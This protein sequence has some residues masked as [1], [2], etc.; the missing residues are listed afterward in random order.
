MSNDH[1]IACRC[2]QSGAMDSPRAIDRR[3]VMGNRWNRFADIR[4]GLLIFIL[5]LIAGLVPSSD[6]C[7]PGGRLIRR[8]PKS[9]PPLV[10]K[11]HIP[12]V[13]EYSI[14]ASGPREGRIRKFNKRFQELVINYNPDIVFKDEE[15]TGEDRIMSVVSYVWDFRRIWQ[16]PEVRIS[17]VG[18]WRS[19]GIFKKSI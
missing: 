16:G 15:G 7:F 9:E 10:Y 8:L 19:V 6:A 12:N 14:S 13:P 2:R 17:L 3:L 1:C 11:Q 5:V 4:F 18:S